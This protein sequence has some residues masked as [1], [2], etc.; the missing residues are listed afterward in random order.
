MA[1]TALQVTSSQLQKASG[2][3]PRRLRELDGIRGL[4]ILM[5]IVYHYLNYVDTKALPF[6]RLPCRLLDI[7]WS[8][9][10]LFFVLSGFLI[11]G[12]LLDSRTSTTYY[13]TFYMRRF[14]RILPLYTVWL[15]AFSI[16][17]FAVTRFGALQYSTVFNS[18]IPLASF[19]LFA[20]NFFQAARQS[21]GPAWMDI[22]WSLAAEEQFYLLLPLIIRVLDRRRL[23][24]FSLLAIAAAPILRVLLAAFGNPLHGPYVLLPCRADAFGIGVLISLLSRTESV[25]QRIARNRSYI[26]LAFIVL[27]SASGIL[28]RWPRRD[29]LNTFG[30]TT[31]A[32]LYGCLILLSMINPGRLLRFVFFRSV[33]PSVGTMAYGLYIFHHGLLGL[34]HAVAFGEPPVIRDVKTC[35]I[36]MGAFVCTVLLAIA[37][38]RYFEKPF[39]RCGHARYSYGRG[40]KTAD[41]ASSS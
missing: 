10:D 5:V 15:V 27:L 28:I 11:A 8:G 20:Q 16:G 6:M 24:V 3:A 19:P 40:V 29:F 35:A 32:M 4:A 31:L 37:S 38:W 36:S 33:L 14:H 17:L 34:A 39:I 22:T 9:V 18:V 12:I 30:F 25:W 2:R 1:C 13:R 23:F 21:F 26:V 7:T 41:L